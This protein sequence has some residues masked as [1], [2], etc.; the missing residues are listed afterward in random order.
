MN[1]KIK[2]GD[3]NAKSTQ[4]E[5]K[6]IQIISKGLNSS[7]EI[8]IDSIWLE[9]PTMRIALIS[10][11]TALTVV[12]GYALVYIPNVELFTMM[13]FLSGFLLGKKNGAIIG[14]MSGFIFCFFNPLGATALPLLSY[15]IFHYSFVGFLGA[16]SHNFLSN[17]N[18]F[19]PEDDLYVFPVLL[20]FGIIGFLITLTYDILSSLVDSYFLFGTLDAFIPY[21]ISG[22]F[23]TTVHE[24]GNTLVFIF[25]L[26]GTIQIGYKLL[27]IKNE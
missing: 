22:L 13:N 12:T 21:F 4:S 11:F 7:E 17:R 24:I 18:F 26:P 2:N 10:I 20:F 5:E 16:V 14:A 3:F 1:I 6:E 25:V 15:Q 23:F 9:R 19:K 8:E 27:D